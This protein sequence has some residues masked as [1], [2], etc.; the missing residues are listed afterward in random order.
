MESNQQLMVLAHS[1][2]W[3]VLRSFF[4]NLHSPNSRQ[5]DGHAEL[6]D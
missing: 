2:F 5:G 3:S 1:M 4:E 6:E